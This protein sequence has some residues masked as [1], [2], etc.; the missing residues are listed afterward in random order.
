[1]YPL[2]CAV[3]FVTSA[4]ASTI[5]KHINTN[6]S[7]PSCG[8]Y[9]SNTRAASLRPSATFRNDTWSRG[10]VSFSSQSYSCIA[11]LSAILQFSA[12]IRSLQKKKDGYIPLSLS[13]SL[14]LSLASRSPP[15]LLIFRLLLR[16]FYSVSALLN[17]S[18][19]YF[20][21]P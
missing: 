1:M 20:S 7:P 12:G 14:S 5:H 19:L 21:V 6:S 18:I 13:L 15:L 10:R 2:N 4:Y 17:R 16:F 3:L 8:L 9:K 11:A